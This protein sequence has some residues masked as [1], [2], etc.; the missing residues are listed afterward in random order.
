MCNVFVYIVPL[1]LKGAKLPLCEVVTTIPKGGGT[2]ACLESQ[3]SQI[4]LLLWHSS[5]KEQN[6]SSLLNRKD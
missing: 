3:R 5:F 6:V 4:R 2:G 1:E